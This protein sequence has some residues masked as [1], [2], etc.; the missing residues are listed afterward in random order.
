MSIWI[1]HALQL[2]VP[3]TGFDAVWYHLPVAYQNVLVHNFTFNP[4]L[5]QSA[6]PLFS[7]SIFTLGYMWAGEF[8]TKLVGYLFALTLVFLSYILSTKFVD[9][10]VGLV[11][12][13]L[14]SCFQVV[15]WQASSFYIDVAVAVWLIGFV[16]FSLELWEK[17]HVSTWLAAGL[18][19]GAVIASKLFLIVLV[20]LIFLLLFVNRNQNARG[21]WLFWFVV[22]MTVLPHYG[23]AWWHL[24]NPFYSLFH[25]I[26]GIGAISAQKTAL[27]YLGH[28]TKS[29]PTIAWTIGFSRDYTTPLLWLFLPSSLY[30]WSKK[31]LNHPDRIPLKIL[32]VFSTTLLVIWWYVPPLS[33]RYGLAGFITA[34]LFT[35]TVITDYL[36]QRRPKLRSALPF[37]LL[38]FV[39]VAMTPR[40]YVG[41]RSMRYILG[42][43]TKRQYLNQFLDGNIDTVLKKWHRQTFE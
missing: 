29:L 28:Q 40:L 37:F 38:L 15:A 5:Y 22:A 14:V 43:Q 27:E 9:R 4:A 20:P 7:D 18:C 3:E 31:N 10:S 13:A 32:F 12:V 24:G 25:H 34:L 26:N 19:F 8:G 33:V 11:F 21:F 36:G 23:F 6:N 1:L 2:F 42:H 35:L 16:W 17:D 30:F 39:I 41:A